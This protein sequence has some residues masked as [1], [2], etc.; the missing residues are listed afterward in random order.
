MGYLTLQVGYNGT[1]NGR[2]TRLGRF[3]AADTTTRA[4][5]EGWSAAWTVTTLMIWLAVCAHD[6]GSSG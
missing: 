2:L 5:A 3:S 6:T 4:T 1:V